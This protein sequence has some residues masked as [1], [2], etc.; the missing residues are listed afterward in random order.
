MKNV[1]ARSALVR[2]AGLAALL[3]LTWAAYTQAPPPAPFL[4]HKVADDLFVID[5]GGAGNVAV[6]VTG[7][8]VILVDDKFDRNFAEIMAN[9]KKVTDQPVRYIINTHYHSDHS[10]GNTMFAPTGVQIIST[11]AA[12]THILNKTQPN[13]QANMVPASVVFDSQMSVFLGGKEVR[14]MH[15]GRGHTGT[16]AMVYFPARRVIHSGDAV[17][18]GLPLIDYA[19]GGS[20]VEWTKTLDKALTTVEWDTMIPGHGPVSPPTMMTTYRDNAIALRN[21]IQAQVR[22]GKSEAEL[23]KFLETEYKWGPQSLQIQ[24]GAVKGLMAELK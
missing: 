16:D 8:G 22:S 11:A 4:L 7:E 1:F 21:K 20:I 17:T 6:Y 18:G 15:L 3:T 13:A 12:R 5:G 14:A 10:G 19:S 2:F 9:I 23:A 24:M